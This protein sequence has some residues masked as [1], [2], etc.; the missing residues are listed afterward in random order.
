MHDSVTD[1]NIAAT[2]IGPRLLA[3]PSQQFE[4]D[5]AIGFAILVDMANNRGQRLDQ[6]G[7]ADDPD[8]LTVLDDRNALDALALKQCGDG[9]LFPA[10]QNKLANRR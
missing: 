5:L 3:Q 8:E 7:A 6:I 2:E 9:N 10:P 4:P 1:G